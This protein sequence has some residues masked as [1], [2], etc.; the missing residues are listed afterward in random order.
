MP[1][2]DH[3]EIW[4]PIVGY[5]GIYSVSSCGRV[6]REVNTKAAKAGYFLAGHINRAGYNRI[7]LY[8]QGEKRKS[9]FMHRVVAA[10]FIGPR[11]TALQVNHLN[12]IKSDNRIENLEYCSPSMNT[13]HFFATKGFKKSPTNAMIARVIRRLQ[14]LYGWRTKDLCGMF[15]IHSRTVHEIVS[16]NHWNYV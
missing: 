15:K 11:P 8:R 14:S 4:K 16:G 3:T 10:A 5:E 9:E 7:C 13:R 12:G 1:I 2:E 6:R